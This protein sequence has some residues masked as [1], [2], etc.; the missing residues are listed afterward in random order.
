MTPSIRVVSTFGSDIDIVSSVK[1]FA[2]SLS[3]T[4]SFSESDIS[5]PTR[6]TPEPHTSTPSHRLSVPNVSTRS[7][8]SLSPSLSI[9]RITS[10]STH[11]SSSTSRRQS[12]S[13]SSAPVRNKLFQFVKKTGASI[14]NRL[15]NVKN[16]AL[17]KQFGKT[18]QCGSKNCKCCKMVSERTTFKY[19]DTVVKAVKGTCSSHNLIYLFECKICGK[20]YI[21]RSVRALRTR[22]GEHRRNFYKVCKKEEY[23][24]NSDEYALA[25]HLYSD[26]LISDRENFDPNYNVSLLDLC[27][28]QILEEKEHNFIHLMH[29]LAPNGLNLNNPFAI[30]LLY[31]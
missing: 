6:L 7:S 13:N 22:V 15:V 4:R 2:T 30:P 27:S 10:P 18:D 5:D 19:K 26:H 31:R 20:H 24:K 16:L 14:K 11:T 1:K 12:P 9:S 29:S 21:G 28:P 8:R 3:R 17:R 25:H 23:D